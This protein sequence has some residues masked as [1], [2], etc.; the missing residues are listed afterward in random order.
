MYCDMFILVK[1]NIKWWKEWATY[2]GNTMKGIRVIALLV[3][4]EYF[5]MLRTAYGNSSHIDNIWCL[6]F[7]HCFAYS[8]LQ[9][10]SISSGLFAY[11]ISNY[12]P[13]SYY[14]VL[15]L[16]EFN[17]SQYVNFAFFRLPHLFPLNHLVYSN[18]CNPWVLS[19]VYSTSQYVNMSL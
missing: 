10:Y 19:Q 6:P 14:F 4:E 7:I 17:M 18:S 5:R 2:I 1:I 16:N 13:S 12:P 11:R 3:E 15:F 9:T 8:I